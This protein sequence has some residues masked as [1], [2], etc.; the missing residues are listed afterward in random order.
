MVPSKRVL[1]M[2]EFFLKATVGFRLIALIG[3]GR[4]AD[5]SAALGMTK[6]RVVV[7]GESGCKRREW[8]Q[9]DK[10]SPRPHSRLS[11][12]NCPFL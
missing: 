9:K 7:N 2:Y 1:R 5:P 11:F 8:L 6:G 12:D 3:V 4:T 10:A